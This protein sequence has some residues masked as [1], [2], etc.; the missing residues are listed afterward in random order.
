MANKLTA[1]LIAGARLTGC[2]VT[3]DDD[4]PWLVQVSAHDGGRAER[5]VFHPGPEFADLLESWQPDRVSSVSCQYY[6]ETG[7]YLPVG[8]AQRAALGVVESADESA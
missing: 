5:R 2:S 1:Y 6:I 3:G 7:F 4:G 8:P